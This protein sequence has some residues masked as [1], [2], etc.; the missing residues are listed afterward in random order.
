MLLH[1]AVSSGEP[2]T[3]AKAFG[4]DLHPLAEIWSP[5]A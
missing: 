5:G 3:T 2:E 1:D 4:I